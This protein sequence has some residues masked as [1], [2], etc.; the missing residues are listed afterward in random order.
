M[1]H[2]GI[3]TKSL[4]MS[5]RI[6]YVYIVTNKGNTV[7]YTG[8]TNNLKRRVFEHKTKFNA[9]SFTAKYNVNKLV[10]Y[11]MFSSINQAIQR[12]KQLKA[13][14]RKKKIMLIESKNPEWIDLYPLVR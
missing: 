7:I 14:S 3:N 13:G 12:E 5:T 2:H 8:V 9:R 1:P 10:Y 6:Y 11:E 4:I